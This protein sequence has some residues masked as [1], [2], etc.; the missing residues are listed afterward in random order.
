MLELSFVRS[1]TQSRVAELL[2]LLAVC[3]SDQVVFEPDRGPEGDSCVYIRRTLLTTN[4]TTTED[5]EDMDSIAMRQEDV[6][7]FRRLLEG[8]KSSPP[9]RWYF[10]VEK[11]LLEFQSEFISLDWIPWLARVVFQPRYCV[12]SGYVVQTNRFALVYHNWCLLDNWDSVERLGQHIPFSV[13]MTKDGRCD[14]ALSLGL[15]TKSYLRFTIPISDLLTRF[16]KAVMHE[17]DKGVNEKKKATLRKQTAC[18]KAP[19]VDLIVPNQPWLVKLESLEDLL[20]NSSVQNSSDR[21]PDLPID[22]SVLKDV[23]SNLTT[24]ETQGPACKRARLF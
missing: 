20:F 6:V 7:L 19:C 14:K 24:S 13:K 10:N 23:N 8:E 16:A 3:S 1:T 11:R 22:L 21:V 15:R 2:R 18:N 12:A 4:E 17:Q 5:Q 9:A